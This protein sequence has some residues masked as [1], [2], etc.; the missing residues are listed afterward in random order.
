MNWQSLWQNL[1]LLLHAT[2]VSIQL[3]ICALTVGLSMS[4][5]FALTLENH[6][7]IFTAII[8]SYVFVFRGTPMLV[9]FFIIYY[10][11]GQ[12]KF[13][14]HGF[15]WIAFKQP[16]FCAAFTLALNTAAYTTE[17]FR[18]AIRAIPHGEIEAAQAFGMSKFLIAIRVILTIYVLTRV[19]IEWVNIAN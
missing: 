14:T 8:K 3:L 4:V 9:Q 13:I 18:G 2:W 10:G 19:W 17:L 5:I 15:L 16:F 12:F 1:P 6:K 11:A 7:N